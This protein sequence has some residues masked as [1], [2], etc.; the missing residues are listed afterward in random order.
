[1]K[2]HVRSAQHNFE[3]QFFSTTV[4]QLSEETRNAIDALLQAMMK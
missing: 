1:L 4:E 3:K 2:R